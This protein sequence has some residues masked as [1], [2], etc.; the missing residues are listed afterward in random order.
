MTQRYIN[1]FFDS[2][3]NKINRKVDFVLFNNAKA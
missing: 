1:K 2:L 3:Q